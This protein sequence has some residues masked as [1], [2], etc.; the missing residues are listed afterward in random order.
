MSKVRRDEFD[1]RPEWMFEELGVPRPESRDASSFK[2]DN[3][4]DHNRFAEF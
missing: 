4:T 3:A 2:I 1:A